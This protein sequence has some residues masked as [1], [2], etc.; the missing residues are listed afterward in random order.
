MRKVPVLLAAFVLVSACG[1]SKPVPTGPDP[2]L[3]VPLIVRVS[4]TPLRAT[5]VSGNGTTS[6]YRAVADITLS[7][8]RGTG[9]QLTQARETTTITFLTELGVIF[10][11][12]SSGSS[13]LPL[14]IPPGGTTTQS[15]V[16]HVDVAAGETVTWS[17]EV[18]GTDAQGREFLA[19]SGPVPVEL[20]ASGAGGG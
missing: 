5:F 3:A 8:S 20:V 16:V 2:P 9:V 18:S 11:V 7:E 19:S 1:D 10:S 17:F 15:R 14:H 6:S 4:P 12:A 13:N